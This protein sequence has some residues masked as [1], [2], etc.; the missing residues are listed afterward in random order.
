MNKTINSISVYYT[1]DS[2]QKPLDTINV[3]VSPYQQ[4]INRANHLEFTKFLFQH[5]CQHL[6]LNYNHISTE[7]VFNFYVNERIAY[8]LGTLINTELARETFYH[9]LIQNTSLPTNYNFASIITEINK[10]IEHYIQQKYPITY[11]SKDKGK[12]QT[13]AKHRVESPTNLSYHYT[14][15]KLLGPY[16]EYFEGFQ[17]QTPTP[18]GIRSLLP[19]PDFG[20][21]NLWKASELEEKKESENQEFTYQNPIPE[22]PELNQE[23][24]ETE[25][26]NIQTPR[27]QN[28]LNPDSINQSNLPSNIAIN[29]PPINL[30][31]QPLLQQPNQQ[32][33]QPQQQL[34]LPVQQQQ[35]NV[36]PMAYAPIAK[37]D[38]FTG[39]EN[40]AQV[41]L[42]NVEKAIITNGWNDDFN[43]FKLEFLRYFSNNNSINQLTNTFITIKQGDTEAVTT[44]LE[45]FCQNLHQIQAINA[46]YFTALQILNQFIRGL[47]SSILQCICSMHSADLQAAVTNAR[48]FE[49]AELEA[50]HAQAVNLV[51]NESSELDSKLK[52]FSNSIN[53][54]LEEYLADNC[55]IYQPSQQCN[56]LGIT[57]CSENQS[58]PLSSTNQ[59]W[60]Q[61][62]HICHYC[63]KQGHLRINCQNILTKLHTYD[64]ATNLSANS[65]CYLLF[66]ASTHLLATA[67]G[68]LPA[69]TNSNTTTELISKQ[70]SKAKTGTAKLEIVDGG[71]STDFRFYSTT[72]RFSTMKF[73]YQ[74]DPKSKFP[75]LFKSFVLT[76][77]IPL[78]TITNNKT[79]AAIFPFELE[80]TTTVPLFNGATLEEKLIMAMYTDVKVDDHFIKLI[81][82]SRS[83]G[84]IIIKQLIDQLGCRVDH[85]T[86]ARIITTDETTKTP[87]GEID[88]FPFKVNDI[89]TPINVLVMEAIQYQALVDNDWLSKTNAIFDWTTQELQLSQNGQH[90]HVPATCGHFKTTNSTIPLIEFEKEEKKPTWEAYQLTPNW[91]WKEENDKRKGKEKEEETTTTNTTSSNS[92]TYPTLPQSTYC[93]PKLI[94]INC[95]KKLLLMSAC[96]G[97]DKKYAM[98]TKFYCHACV[99]ERFG[100][101]K[102]QEKWD[103]QSCLVCGETLLDERMWNNIPEQEGMCD[104][105][106]QYTI[107]ISDWIR[108]GTLIKTAWK[109]AVQQLDS[110]LHDDNKIWQIAFVKIERALPEEIREIKNNPPEPIELDWDSEPVINLLELEEF[111]K[112]YQHLAPTRE[113]QEQWLKQLNARLC[114][115]CLILSDFEY[116]NECDLIYNPPPCMI[117]MILKEKKPISNCTLELESVFD[118]DS[119]PNNNN[120]KN[121]SSSSAQNDNKN[122]SNSDSNS[123]SEIYIALPDLSKEQE[124]K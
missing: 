14:P 29:Y 46:N 25:T 53:Q 60:Q 44:Y 11:S 5:Y 64:A 94:C 112:H 111:Y 3:L 6:G 107:L 12:L 36:D 82:N 105:S 69:T 124:L 95:G 73:R 80:E 77:N 84:N 91:E 63:G 68:N 62:M 89:I 47:C 90:T 59:S 98:V 16:G 113:E 87:I 114:H 71:L 97:D 19:L 57:N 122:I 27:N 109:K 2:T 104:K 81:L 39:K 55:A 18:S 108:K 93:R 30:I 96:C 120:D 9:E 74:F 61:E 92:Y 48:D 79:L 67:S 66:T 34:Q 70:N 23:N 20:I 121:T 40:N 75:T 102:K 99:I 21:A 32:I 45:R 118:P 123:N 7:S 31:A 83:A 51:M 86:S 42:N 115:Y 78:A 88:N 76:N 54:K 33:Q 8:L 17:S 28:I 1:K 24:P 35:P 106:C 4:L 101:P 85:A 72:I 119:N 37:L 116:C 50:N 103:N 13:P 52:Q 43:A 49:A 26:P 56:N 10:E 41:W 117:Y 38:N 58:H 15:K 100:R 22:N 65:T 110:C